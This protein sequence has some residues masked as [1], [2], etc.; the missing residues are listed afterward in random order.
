V[1]ANL[2]VRDGKLITELKVFRI[3]YGFIV[4]SPEDQLA[5]IVTVMDAYPHPFTG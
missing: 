4:E 3:D 5:L 2:A 1:F